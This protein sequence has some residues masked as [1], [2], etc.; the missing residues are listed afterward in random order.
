MDD[1]QI[2]IVNYN[3]KDSL[4]R[5]LRSLEQDLLDSPL[6][7]TVKVIDNNSADDLND[8]PAQFPQLRGVTVMKHHENNGFGA[9]HNVLAAG[10]TARL[11]LILNPDTEV[12]EKQTI[13]RLVASLDAHDAQ[14]VGPELLTKTGKVQVW[15]HGELHGLIAKLALS[16]GHSY[17][18]VQK[19]DTEVAWVSGAVFLITRDWFERVHGFDEAFF[20]YKEEEDLCVRLREHGARIVYDPS[21]RMFHEGSVVASKS[22]HIKKSLAHFIEKHFKHKKRYPFIKLLNSLIG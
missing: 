22:K 19:K 20:L 1:L 6:S 15:D 14:V 3:T 5:C 13:A 10:S 17:W 4:V 2:Q 7:Y 8:I 18:K 12:I 11:L 9:G 16:I 21:I